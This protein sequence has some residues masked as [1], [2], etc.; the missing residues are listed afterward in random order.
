MVSAAGIHQADLLLPVPSILW[1]L[2]SHLTAMVTRQTHDTALYQQGLAILDKGA[3][4]NILE[5]TVKFNVLM[6]TVMPQ[7]CCGFISK[8]PQ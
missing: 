4:A 1:G 2:L 8:L 6:Y 3:K 7:R 5:F